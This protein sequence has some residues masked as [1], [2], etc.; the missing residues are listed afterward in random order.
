MS[1]SACCGEVA[2]RMWCAHSMECSAVQCSAVQCS[3]VQC[4]GPSLPLPASR[5][6]T[7][8]LW[9][10]QGCE[11]RSQCRHHMRGVLAR[12]RSRRHWC[13]GW[14]RVGVEIRGELAPQCSSAATT[15][16]TGDIIMLH[17]SFECLQTLSRLTPM[18][19]HTTHVSCV[20]F[21]TSPTPL[22]VVV[23]ADVSAQLIVW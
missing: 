11:G 9:S 23:T 15:V 8:L 13:S 17:W 14:N 3:A 6:L 21:V 4:R 1:S 18:I 22:P 2:V 12:P 7:V 10:F 19:G 16:T 5:R 20:T